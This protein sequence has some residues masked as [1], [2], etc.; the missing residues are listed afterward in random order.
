MTASFLTRSAIA[1]AAALSL[2]AAAPAA[3]AQ[4]GTIKIV[5][6]YTPGSGPDIL[7]RLMAEQIGR[8]QGPTVVVEIAPAPAP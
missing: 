8:A 5:V 1:L 7:S 2:A 6:P 4:S 3:W